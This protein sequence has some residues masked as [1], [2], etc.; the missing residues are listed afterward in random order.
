MQESNQGTGQHARSSTQAT[1]STALAAIH[2]AATP[3]TRMIPFPLPRLGKAPTL[4]EQG[5]EAL[6]LAGIAH[7][8]RN[9]MTALGL[10]AELISEP[11]VLTPQGNLASFIDRLVLHRHMWHPPWEAE[12]PETI[13][14]MQNMSPASTPP[15]R[16]RIS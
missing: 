11:G 15:C 10:C 8:A 3:A 12:G 14:P 1:T 4:R 16:M 5:G 6:A 2:A 13:R 7:D 9:L